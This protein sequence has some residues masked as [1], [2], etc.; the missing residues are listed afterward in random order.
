MG[1]MMAP[2]IMGGSRSS[3]IGLPC[4]SNA[5]LKLVLV[6]YAMPAAPAAMPTENDKNGRLPTPSFQPRSSWKLIGY[7]SKKRY[8]MP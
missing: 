2:T 5:L 3:G 1:S 6:E 8:K 4:F 7:A